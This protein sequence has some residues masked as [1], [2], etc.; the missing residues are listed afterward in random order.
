M[1][2]IKTS[3]LVPGMTIAEDILGQNGQ[4]ILP[5]G[6]TLNDKFI[7]YLEFHSILS[8]RIEDDAVCEPVFKADDSTHSVHLRQS[9]EFKKF[10][11]SFEEE[12][13]NFKTSI[14]SIVDMNTE[15]NTDALLENTLSILSESTS[16]YHAF[17]MLHH[18]REYDDSTFAHSMNVAL[19]CNIFAQ[20]LKWSESDQNLL[21]ICGLLHDI[22]KL[23]IPDTIIKKPNRL[24]DNEFKII[25][26]HTIEGYQIL[27]NK[28][29]STHVMNAALMHH[30]KCDGTGYPLALTAEKI[31]RFAK[32]VAIADVYDALTSARIYRGPTCPFRVIEIFEAEG[33]R[34]YEPEYLMTFLENI[35]NT[36]LHNEVLLSN[37]ETATVV[38]IN[39]QQ[40]SRP[41]VQQGDKFIDLSK[42]TDLHIVSIL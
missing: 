22:G 24:T 36:Y 29:I 30:E 40:F 41:I 1:R 39:K 2:R 13:E 26:T 18:M 33:L 9:E 31:D 37:N 3:E 21:T 25:K 27:K 42:E 17:D 38:F 7:T 16:T 19:I 20:W 11:E 23:K 15:I 35:V 4:M 5:K 32:A 6:T 34:K 10:H 28:N 12:L 8:V 14:N